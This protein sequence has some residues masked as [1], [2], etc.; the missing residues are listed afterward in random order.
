MKA[1]VDFETVTNPNFLRVWGW[2]ICNIDDPDEIYFGTKIG[3]FLEQCFELDVK[4]GYFHNL[5]FDGEFIIYHLLKNGWK[6]ISSNSTNPKLNN[7]EFST[8]IAS[9]GEFYY[10]KLHAL[11]KTITFY[12]SM[13][14]I[15]MSVSSVA[16]TFGLPISKLSIDYDEYRAEWH[17]LTTI[18]KA[19]I[20]NDVKIMAMALKQIFD[21]GYTKMTQGA[22][23]L[24]DYK[25]I[26]GDKRFKNYFPIPEY[27]DDI[28]QCYKGGWCYLNP[29][30]KS[31]DVL[32]GNVFDVNSLY[33]SRMYYEKLPWGKPVY[34]RG[35]YPNFPYY[36][37]YIQKLR[38]EFE[39]KP[40]KLPTIQLKNSRGFEPTEY[41]TSSKGDCITLCLCRVDYELFVEHY[42]VFNLEF[43]E[44]WMFRSNDKLFREYIDKWIEVKNKS[45]LEGNKG[46]RQWAKIMLNSLYGKFALN[47]HCA[48]K[49][50]VLIGDIVNYCIGEP[51]EREPIY[52]P[53]G[54][55]ITAYARNYTIR[56]AQAIRDYSL[57]KYGVDKFIYSDTDSIHTTLSADEC[58]EIIE[59]DEIKLGAWKHESHFDRG[60]FIRAKTY[61]EYIDG[62]LHVTCAGMPDEVKKRVTFDN[63]V[64]GQV[65]NGKLQPR[66]YPGGI[67]LIDTTFSIKE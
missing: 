2:A 6:H 29:L 25:K 18:E 40:G 41:V 62:K 44:G 65:F 11:N 38:C 61:I 15:T 10:I 20:A 16:K 24:A 45:T 49:S 34:Y 1:T 55:F 59:V 22:N 4:V 66:H 21:M 52:L 50:P 37:L 64:C 35:E 33:P 48:K 57:K 51:E 7:K 13:K 67:V 5:K 56:A 3:G 30:Y 39:L 28:R 14:I 23:A 31:R 63:F 27:D 46:M 8:L 60:R 43:I 32:D 36:D 12:D 19:Y 47:P 54:A 26:I 58:R 9:T 17:K 53:V 42:N